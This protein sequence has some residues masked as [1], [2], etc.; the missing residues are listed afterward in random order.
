MST[1][2]KPT[3]YSNYWKFTKND[4]VTGKIERLNANYA[5]DYKDLKSFVLRYEHIKNEFDNFVFNHPKVNIYDAKEAANL[6][7]HST[8]FTISKDL[9]SLAIPMIFTDCVYFDN[10]LEI[11]KLMSQVLDNIDK[12]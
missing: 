9:R 3:N 5:K 12:E 1:I 7:L 10:C 6:I 8:L 11:N 4:Q 2:T